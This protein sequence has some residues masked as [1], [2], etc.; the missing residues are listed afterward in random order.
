MAI[1]DMHSNLQSPNTIFIH[2]SFDEHVKQ[3]SNATQISKTQTNKHFIF[4]IIP[5]NSEW[6]RLSI[7]NRSFPLSRQSIRKQQRYLW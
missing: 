3:F 6:D 2:S 5:K 4:F 7:N 1:L